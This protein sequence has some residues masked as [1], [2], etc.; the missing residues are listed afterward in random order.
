VPKCAR[1]IEST[2]GLAAIRVGNASDS[3]RALSPVDVAF[4]QSAQFGWEQP[5]FHQGEN[6]EFLAV[7]GASCDELGHLVGD[8]CFASGY[9]QGRSSFV[10]SALTAQNS[11]CTTRANDSEPPLVARKGCAK[12]SL[13]S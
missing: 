10:L 9:V 1:S 7:I 3:Q 12:M 5:S 2:S 6:D 4:L 11:L 13:F 8:K